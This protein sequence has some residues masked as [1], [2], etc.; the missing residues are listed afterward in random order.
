MKNKELYAPLI[1]LIS[2]PKRAP[3]FC[4][5]EESVRRPQVVLDREI[6]TQGD[7]ATE[8]VDIVKLLHFCSQ[9]SEA[10]L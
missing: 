4:W 3:P 1:L 5:L 6:L 7:E 2:N 8:K 10:A 9:L